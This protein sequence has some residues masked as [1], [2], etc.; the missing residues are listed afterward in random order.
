METPQQRQIIGEKAWQITCHEAG[1]AI[2]GV[3]LEIPFLHVERGDGEHGE[4]PVGVGPNEEPRSDWTLEE[5]A[6]WQQFYAAGA[7]AERLLF[8]AYREYGARRDRHLHE[9]LERQ[10]RPGRAGGWDQDIRCAMEL[11]DRA[12]VEKVA[13]ELDRQRRLSDEQVY[14]LLDCKPPWYEKQ[15]MRVESRENKGD[16][17][18]CFRLLAE[19]T[20]PPHF[21]RRR[22][23]AAFF[24]LANESGGIAPPSKTSV[25][26]FFHF[27]LPVSSATNP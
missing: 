1:H 6:R 14:E 19:A 3:R 15:P 16:R 10:W 24:D 12:S 8:G 13:R 20:E 11:L 23:A 17:P 2:V 5:I 9:L 21:G 26:V 22:Y 7:A 18:F 27:L 25:S 4:V